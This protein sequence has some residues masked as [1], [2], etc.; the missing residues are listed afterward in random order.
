MFKICL[1]KR[2]VKENAANDCKTWYPV[3]LFVR[4]FTKLSRRTFVGQI[5]QLHFFL[6]RFKSEKAYGI[7][8]FLL[9]KIETLKSLWMSAVLSGPGTNP[10]PTSFA[11]I[12]RVSS[13]W[14]VNKIAPRPYAK[15]SFFGLDIWVSET[16]SG[17]RRKRKSWV[18]L[19]YTCIKFHV[20]SQSY[21]LYITFSFWYLQ[22]LTATIH[23]LFSAALWVHHQTSNF[24][25]LYKYSV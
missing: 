21:L 1:C 2:R 11:P 23:G 8:R 15:S 5:K 3:A 10:A 25:Q 7:Q 18:K 17:N 6:N 9:I 16:K 14:C 13:A 4:I 20:M 19:V 12:V 24:D 22:C